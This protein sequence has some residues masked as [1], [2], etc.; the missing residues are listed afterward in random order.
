MKHCV[1]MSEGKGN[2]ERYA[3]TLKEKTG[4]E[5][6]RVQGLQATLHISTVKN[7]AME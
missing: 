2:V 6:N 3:T 5:E 1:P 4:V 7:Q